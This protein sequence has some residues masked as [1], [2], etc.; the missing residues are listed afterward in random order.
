[1]ET[2]CELPEINVVLKMHC[3]IMYLQVILLNISPM[4]VRF[5]FNITDSE[6]LES[7]SRISTSVVANLR[8]LSRVEPLFTN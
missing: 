3:F 6:V 5:G 2:V 1:M 7:R 8:H 4:L